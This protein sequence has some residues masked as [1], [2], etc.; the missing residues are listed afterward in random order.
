MN[1]PVTRASRLLLRIAVP[2]LALFFAA[3]CASTPPIPATNLQAAQ[4]AIANA[5]RV[6]AATHA[7]AELGEARGKLSSAQRAIEV[8][9]MVTAGQ[10]ADEARADAE[11]A[12]ARSGAAKANAVNQDM[13]HSTETLVDEMQRKTGDSR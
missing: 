13:K 6:D 2:G 7:A 10:L 1:F 5:E 9:D 11:L 3:A 4:Q 12:S 8:E